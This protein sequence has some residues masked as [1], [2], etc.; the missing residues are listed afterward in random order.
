MATKSLLF[1][2]ETLMNHFKSTGAMQSSS[3]QEKVK[4]QKTALSDAF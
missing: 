3:D 4:T 1:V 2:E